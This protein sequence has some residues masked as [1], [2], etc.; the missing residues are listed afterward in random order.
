MRKIGM[1]TSYLAYYHIW[2]KMSA[3]YTKYIL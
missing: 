3:F 1:F 2:K